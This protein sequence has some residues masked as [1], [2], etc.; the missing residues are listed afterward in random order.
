MLRTKMLA[1]VVGMIATLAVTAV[2][3]FAEFSSNSSATSGTVTTG[4]VV[5]EGGG[6][7]LECTS[8][9]GKW[10]ITN[11]QGTEV[12][13]GK[14]ERLAFTTFTGCTAKSSIIKGA[15]ATVKACTLELEQDPGQIKAIGSIVTVR[16]EEHTSEL[17]SLV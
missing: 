10:T 16:S 17:Q 2:P 11:A 14:N 4:A 12:T 8:S 3:A 15:A 9:A 13:Q 7:T 6:A 5:L 1:V